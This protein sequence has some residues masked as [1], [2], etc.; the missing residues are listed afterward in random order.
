MNTALHNELMAVAKK[1][2]SAS[3]KRASHAGPPKPRAPRRVF[4]GP[5]K[6]RKAPKRGADRKPRRA[7]A[8]KP[9]PKPK[10]GPNGLRLPRKS[11]YVK[12]TPMKMHNYE[13]KHYRP[14]G[15]LDM[16]HRYPKTHYSTNRKSYFT[17]GLNK[18]PPYKQLFTKAGR[19]GV[20]PANLAYRPSYDIIKRFYNITPYNKRY[21]KKPASYNRRLNTVKDGVYY[22]LKV[23]DAI[24]NAQKAVAHAEN[25]VK[26]AAAHHKKNNSAV[27]AVGRVLGNI[28]AAPI[29]MAQQLV[30]VMHASPNVHSKASAAKKI[31]AALRKHRATKH[32]PVAP[33]HA[34]LQNASTVPQANRNLAVVIN[35]HVAK[36]KR[37]R[38][39]EAERLSIGMKY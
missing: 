27:G 28:A 37:K 33:I 31:Q 24:A 25:V 32:M 26:M 11:Y 12:K 20:L 19:A 38:M 29:A 36:P 14:T 18:A 23:R 34:A 16:R 15:K 4:F 39:S 8:K 10:L 6:E 17:A 3:A 22:H 9:G 13:L 5:R 7:D 21:E 2:S 35:Q 30:H 1:H